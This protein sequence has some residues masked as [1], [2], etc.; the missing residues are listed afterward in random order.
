MDELSSAALVLLDK[1][2]L[3]INYKIVVWIRTR[4]AKGGFYFVA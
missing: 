4:L 2:N 3:I 1:N